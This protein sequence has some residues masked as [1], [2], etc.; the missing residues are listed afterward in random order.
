MPKDFREIVE[1][2]M[3]AKESEFQRKKCGC[4]DTKKPNKKSKLNYEIKSNQDNL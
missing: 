3:D 1:C 2:M 4:N